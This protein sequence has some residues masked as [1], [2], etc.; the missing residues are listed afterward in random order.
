[1]FY[2]GLFGCNN[3]FPCSKELVQLVTEGVNVTAKYGD[4]AYNKCLICGAPLNRF[5]FKRLFSSF[6]GN[7][8]EIGCNKCRTKYRMSIPMLVVACMLAVTLVIVVEN[9]LAAFRCYTSWVFFPVMSLCFF[10]PFALGP[11]K[12]INRR[13]PYG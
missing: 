6:K 10:V 12:Y 7:S 2:T 3:P 13:D 8:Y 5:S 1:M 9:I 4:L 11:V